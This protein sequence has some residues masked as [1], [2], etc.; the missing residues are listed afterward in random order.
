MKSASSTGATSQCGATAKCDSSQA[1]VLVFLIS[2]R[3]AAAFL[4]TLS[5]VAEASPVDGAERGARP[6]H[7]LALSVVVCSM[8]RSAPA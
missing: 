1:E 4:S 2:D 5:P 6:I 8:A 3:C 7:F